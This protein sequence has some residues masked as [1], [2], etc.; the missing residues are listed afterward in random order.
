MRPVALTVAVLTYNRPEKLR[1]GLPLIMKQIQQL[2]SDVRTQVS[3]DVLVIDNDPAASA[4]PVARS[5]ESERLRYVVEPEPGISAGRNRALDETI[6]RDLLVFIDDDE[7]PREG[8]LTAL[9]DTW[10]DTRAA[11]VM[12]R[13]V[14]KFEGDLD[15]WIAAGEFFRRRRMKTGTEIAVAAAG[16]LLLD[17]R[18]VRPV[19]IRFDNNLGLSGG[20]DTLFSKML[21][22][23]GLR[24]VWC[25]E[26]VADDH[27]AA[28]RVTREW[29]RRR[30]WS[31]G[32]TASLID[33]YLADG[34]A[35]RLRVRGVAACRGLL[36]VAGGIGRYAFGLATRSPRHQARGMR[37]AGRGA[38]MIVGAAGL[39]YQE[40]ARDAG[41]LG[42]R[43][44]RLP[45]G[46]PSAQRPDGR[47]QPAH[48]EEPT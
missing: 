5:N 20:E 41:S 3:A 37:T 38:G 9:L 13:V 7:Q 10:C 42:S 16:N 43:L 1:L 40:Y 6:D 39:V 29:V 2:N 21:V 17:L 24:M 27:V 25:D 28:D 15:P 33:L 31:H 46:W 30:A 32:N 22:R 47:H 35:G 8:W 26:S 11:A 48:R 4:E 19:G 44:H 23:Q 18:Q 34:A 12:G 14:S 36:R 45:P